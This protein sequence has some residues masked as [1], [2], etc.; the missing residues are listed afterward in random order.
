MKKVVILGIVCSLLM[1]G[2]AVSTVEGATVTEATYTVRF[3]TGGGSEI[4]SQR[5][6][7]GCKITEPERPTK[8]CGCEFDGWYVGDEKWSFVGYVVTEDVVLTAK[9]VD[10]F[11]LNAKEREILER[12]VGKFG[13]GT[14]SWLDIDRIEKGSLNENENEYAII[15]F[16]GE[17]QVVG[18]AKS[19]VG[20]E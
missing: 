6:A 9:W 18:I 15:Y 11:G 17:R 5:V 19:L 4:E 14:Y 12:F 2:C 16:D 8:A 10:C 1:G 13:D 20:E 3:D 7:R